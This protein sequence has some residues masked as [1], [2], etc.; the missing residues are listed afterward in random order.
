[1]AAAHAAQLTIFVLVSQRGCDCSSLIPTQYHVQE[2]HRPA[3][4]QMKH[5]QTALFGGSPHDVDCIRR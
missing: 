1:V 4:W 3:N 5:H 2:S